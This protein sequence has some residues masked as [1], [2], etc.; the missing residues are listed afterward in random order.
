MNMR[1]TIMTKP[2]GAVR[3]TWLI[4]LQVGQTYKL[5]DDVAR[6]LILNGYAIEERR[7]GE[8]RRVRRQDSPGRRHTD[9]Q[10]D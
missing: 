1:V 5:K 8:R 3:G 4:S 2:L 10:T 6:E 7:F 9:Y